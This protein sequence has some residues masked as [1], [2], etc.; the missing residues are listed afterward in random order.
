VVLDAATI[1]WISA[2]VA[3]G[4]SVSAPRQTIVNNLIVGLKA[5]GIFT[6]LDRLWLHAAENSQSALTDLIADQAATPSGSPTF[7]ADQGYTFDG[8]AT[9]IDTNFNPSTAGGNFVQDSAHM[10]T[11]PTAVTAATWA[12][13]GNFVVTQGIELPWA[14]DRWFMY[15][16]DG[17]Q[18][19]TGVL[20]GVGHICLTRTAA[21]ARALYA[22]GGAA[23]YSDAAGSTGVASA[24]LYIG[25]INNA[26]ALIHVNTGQIALTSI[27]GGLNATENGNFYNRLRTYMTA[28]GIP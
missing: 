9:F 16:N 7:T 26:G 17:S 24:N 6:K 15:I 1:A 27:G 13:F 10:S 11:W 4:G 21:G 22:N 25:A 5:D 14:T 20:T 3:A 23:A 18:V 8:A 12:Q 2:V 19:N 28:V